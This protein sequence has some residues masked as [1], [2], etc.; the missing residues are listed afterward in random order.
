MSV[1]SVAGLELRAEGGVVVA[2][3][4]APSGNTMSLAMCEALTSVLREPPQDAHV[5]VIEARG[6]D[7]C[8]GRERAA[9]TAAEMVDEV[10][11]LTALNE[12]LAESRLVTVA[13]VQGDTAG[14]GVGIVALCDVAV[15]VRSARFWFPEVAL[16]L[17]PTLVL[18]WLPTI[19]G[20]RDAFWLTATGEK[21]DGDEAARL[22]LVN[23]SVED[24]AALDGEIAR[25][26]A[27]LTERSPSV[28]AGIRSMLQISHPV[29]SEF[30]STV[31]ADRLVIGS[32]RRAGA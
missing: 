16:G 28:H 20:R 26:V 11:R 21:I 15:T 24:S 3:L 7:F 1:A 2:T 18:A 13:K 25:R 29:T 9:T 30:A 4:D 5:L 6:A 22:G 32:L 17:A 27:A 14:F 23:Q 19:I 10:A 12:A 8:L 31:A